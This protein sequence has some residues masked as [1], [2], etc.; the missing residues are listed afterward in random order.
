M[1]IA[2]ILFFVITSDVKG[3]YTVIQIFYI[4]KDLITFSTKL[5]ISMIFLLWY[6]LEK[7]DDEIWLSDHIL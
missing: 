4:R 2:K 1:N 5:T 3:I 7:C 6:I